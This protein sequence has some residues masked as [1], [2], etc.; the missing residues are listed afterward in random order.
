MDEFG[1]IYLRH[2][3][4]SQELEQKIAKFLKQKTLYYMLLF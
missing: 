4:N 1:A 2:S 3:R